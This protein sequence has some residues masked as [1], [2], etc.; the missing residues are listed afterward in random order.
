ME[1]ILS[2]LDTIDSEVLFRLYIP[3]DHFQE[4]QI[5]SFLKLFED[6]MQ[7]V[8]K[9]SFW[10]DQ[11]KSQHGIMF[12]FKSTNKMTQES[13][14]NSV[15]RFNKFLA[16][17]Q[18]DLEDARKILLKAKIAPIDAEYLLTRYIRDY[19]RIQLDVRHDLEARTLA[20]KQR[21]ENELFDAVT[22]KPSA[23]ELPSTQTNF[24]SNTQNLGTININ[25][26]TQSIFDNSVAQN[27]LEETF[28]GDISYGIEEKQ[29]IDLFEK[30]AEGLEAVSLKSELN[31]LK[32]KT[33]NS[34]E[35]QTAWKK[36]QTFLT[37]VAPII[38][39]KLIDLLFEY[40]RKAYLPI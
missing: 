27:I 5:S 21:L 18:N 37:K 15:S 29:I 28:N 31:I 13:I 12:V 17:A 6:Y 39:D 34:N 1:K 38:G 3:K 20:L 23:K 9:C 4:R 36:I 14:D 8:A 11:I 33:M 40:L 16:L 10:I 22:F 19:N 30:Y 25:F 26:F 24:L 2:L 35:R 7:N 32:D